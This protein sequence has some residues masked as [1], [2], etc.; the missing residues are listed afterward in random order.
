MT[1]LT[2]LFIATLML[3]AIVFITGTVL[4]LAWGTRAQKLARRDLP[5]APA[6]QAIFTGIGRLRVQSAGQAPMLILADIVFPY[7]AA[8]RSFSDEL[9]LQRAEL[10]AAVLQFLAARTPDELQP[11]AEG[12]LRAGLRD[13]I[14]SQLHLGAIDELW[15]AAFDLLP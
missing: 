6:G 15:F 3:L 14:N 5:A 7:D 12:T 10:R 13:L 8:D 9:F 1:R 11:A 2:K 4:A